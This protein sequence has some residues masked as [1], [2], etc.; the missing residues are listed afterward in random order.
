AGTLDEA[1]ECVLRRVAGRGGGYAC[2]CGVHGI[3]LA[4][5]RPSLMA[6]LDGAWLDFPD[7]AP[8]AWLMRRVGCTRA[9]RIAGPDLMPRTIELGQA[10]G[11]RHF[12]LGSTPEV[13]EQL[14]RRIERTYP[15]AT[16]AGTCSPPFRALSA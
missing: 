13:L 9:R 4:K 16:I 15:D 5:H 6:A 3:V 12:L 1:A 14:R 10:L 8:V 11:V 2:L 7:G